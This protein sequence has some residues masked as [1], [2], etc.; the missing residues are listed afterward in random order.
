MWMIWETGS[1]SL[2]KI[3]ELFGR[4]K[5]APVAQRIRRTRCSHDAVEAR[6]LIAEMFRYDP[7]YPEPN[8]TPH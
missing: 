6:K 3:G 2:R 1:K 4:L 8:Y 7:I 5:C